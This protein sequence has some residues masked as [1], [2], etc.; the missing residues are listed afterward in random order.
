M[1]PLGALFKTKASFTIIVVSF[2][3]T[4]NVELRSATP[5]VL[6][7]A[8]VSATEKRVKSYGRSI[9]MIEPLRMGNYEPIM[10]WS[11]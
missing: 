8:I 3:E 5:I 10:N 11:L 7:F 4:A 9:Y 6:E 1:T 2:R